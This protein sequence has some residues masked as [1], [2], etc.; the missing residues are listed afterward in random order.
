ML[1]PLEV[2][3][4]VPD[5]KQIVKELDRYII[6]QEDAKKALALLVFARGMTVL[7]DYGKISSKIKFKRENLM[8]IGPT[9]C[10]KS[11][12]VKTLADIIDFPISIIDS[13][14]ITGNGWH[15]RDIDEVLYDHMKSVAEFMKTKHLLLNEEELEELYYTKYSYG[16]IYF[17]EFDKNRIRRDEGHLSSQESTQSAFLKVLEGCEMEI[18]TGE[19]NQT[20]PGKYTKQ[21]THIDTSK[22]SFIVGGTFE[23]IE[24]ITRKRLQKKGGIGFTG[25]VDFSNHEGKSLLKHVNTDD[26]VEYGFMREI[27][28]RFSLRAVLDPLTV[29]ELSDILVV[30]ENNPVS[31]YK[32]VFKVFGIDLHLTREAIRQIAEIAKDMN[33]GARA[34]ENLLNKVLQPELF[35]IY[36]TLE[37]KLIITKN[38]VIDRC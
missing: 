12:L 1:A 36:H 19:Y 38:I 5:P 17:D 20:V 11:F 33:T 23:G 31:R 24:D 3:E 37:E 15:G 16:I 27:V 8:M 21:K 26:L 6:G 7:Q 35:N 13:T 10:G 28:G 32:E 34:L 29:N 2:M 9:G 30:P 18:G 14:Q 25:I 4:V 22:L